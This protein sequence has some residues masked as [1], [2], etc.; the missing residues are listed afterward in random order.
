MNR[1]VSPLFTGWVIT[2]VTGEVKAST[3]LATI[4]SSPLRATRSHALSSLARMQH[5]FA[6]I[7]PSP[8]C[9]LPPSSRRTKVALCSATAERPSPRC[10]GGHHRSWSRG[11]GEERGLLGSLGFGVHFLFAKKL[12][13]EC[14]ASRAD[15][16]CRRGCM[17]DDADGRGRCATARALHLPGMY[18]LYPEG[19][20]SPWKGA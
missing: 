6:C 2:A 17:D 15:S 1:L 16:R 18:A 7:W 20:A 5:L 11:I 10:V 12:N 14:G 9:T 4:H 13:W 19:H 3:R 8:R